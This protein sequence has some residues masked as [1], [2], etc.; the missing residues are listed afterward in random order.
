[1]DNRHGGSLASL[2]SA[3]QWLYQEFRFSG[4]WLILNAK[5]NYKSL[6]PDKVD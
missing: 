5:A 3:L 4:Y 6:I 1:M 2:R